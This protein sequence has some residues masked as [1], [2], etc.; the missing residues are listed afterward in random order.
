M[1]QDLLSVRCAYIPL[2]TES[3]PRTSVTGFLK[4]MST[5]S[6]RN[7]A[8][9][10]TKDGILSQSWHNGPDIG[11]SD[12]FHVNL[13]TARKSVCP[14]PPRFAVFSHYLFA[15]AQLMCR[16]FTF[17][18]K[19]EKEHYCTMFDQLQRTCHMWSLVPYPDG[20]INID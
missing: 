6:R 13:S 8:F 2:A 12:F 5:D 10:I 4:D 14:D 11:V 18:V 9:V 15:S 17:D 20:D 16:L 19:R 7:A 1:W 3:C